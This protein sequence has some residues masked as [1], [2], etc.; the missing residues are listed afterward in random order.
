MSGK[1]I[2]SARTLAFQ[3]LQDVLGEG[4]YANIA[5]SKRLN[6]AKLSPV[7]RRFATELVYGTIKACGTLDWMVGHYLKRPLT[8]TDPLVV[9]ILRLG[10]YQ[11]QFLD[12]IPASAAVNEAVNLAKKFAHPGA[13]GFVNAVLR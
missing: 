2:V 3:V 13:S 4:A 10:M 9:N 5:L 11:L 6:E 12:K 7:D 1:I 8:Q